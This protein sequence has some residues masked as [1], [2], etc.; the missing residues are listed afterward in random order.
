MTSAQERCPVCNAPD[1]LVANLLIRICRACVDEY[2]PYFEGIP[3]E[4][5]PGHGKFARKRKL[6]DND[7]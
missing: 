6:V 3:D 2:D 4:T 1:D 7:S 5:E